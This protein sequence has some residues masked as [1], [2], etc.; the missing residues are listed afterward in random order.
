MAKRKDFIGGLSFDERRKSRPLAVSQ[1]AP[2]T[3]LES[4]IQEAFI[5]W[6]DWNV[7][8]HPLLR[9]ITH[10]PNGG[11]RYIATAVALQRQGVQRGVPDM[12]VEIPAKGFHAMRIEFKRGKAKLTDEQEEWRAH[13]EAMGFKYVVCRSAVEAVEEVV[14]YLQLE[15]YIPLQRRE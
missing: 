15:D 12:L 9:F 6:R 10:V 8:R 13:Y 2:T 5:A 1:S 11:H 7:A 4:K 14:N 3:E